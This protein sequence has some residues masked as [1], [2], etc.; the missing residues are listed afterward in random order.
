MVT[1]FKIDSVQAQNKFVFDVF[2]GKWKRSID[3]I[4]MK[5]VFINDFVN[6]DLY[7]K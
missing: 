2:A 6:H 3:P 1:K 5:C 7:F 4:I